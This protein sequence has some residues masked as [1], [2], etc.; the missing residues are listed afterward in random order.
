M[1]YHLCELWFHRALAYQ[2]PMFRATLAM[3]VACVFVWAVGGRT[4]RMLVRLRIGDTAKFDHAMLDDYM[5]DKANVPT[6]G[7]VMILGAILFATLT[8]ARLDNFYVW[9]ALFCVVWLGTLG[10]ADDYL[11]LTV[12]RRQG[13]R[14]GL[15]SYEK[16]LFQ[17]ALAVML[18]YFIYHHGSRTDAMFARF[19]P[20]EASIETYRI[21]TVPFY[22]GVFVLPLAVFMIVTVLVMAGTSNA[23]NFT[24][25]LDG[26][27][28]GCTA[29]VSFFF[30]LLAYAI[31]REGIA[32]YL[33]MWHVPAT[34][35]LAVPCG[36]A[37]GACL[38]FL[39]FNCHPARVFMG[40]TGSLPLGGLIG[41]VAIVLRQE[42]ILFI[43]GGVFVMEAVSVMMQV[44]YFKLT[45]GKRIFRVSP[46][47]YHFRLG[48]WTESQ[49]VI[50]FWL[51][52][53]VCAI[54]AL[55]TLKLR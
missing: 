32:S 35:E 47:H 48:G 53:V 3:I 44:G 7:G 36:A 5:H 19:R 6:M 38:G 27:A 37:C 16:L 11:K 33:L 54:V 12:G 24:D 34:D 8:M 30:M 2:N 45:G 42:L 49:T 17:I 39:W 41:Y 43:V 23:V 50:R 9:M 31:G 21:F 4:I 55:L 26:L 40:D 14:T 29:M 1:F 18:A 28:A 52:A 46:I 20:T 25:G 15:K 22:K 51:L 10:G 13:S